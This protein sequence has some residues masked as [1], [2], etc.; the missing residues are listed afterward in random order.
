MQTMHVLNPPTLPIHPD[1]YSYLVSQGIFNLSKS[2]VLI[3]QQ[4]FLISP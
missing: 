2:P 4:T 1:D 3:I